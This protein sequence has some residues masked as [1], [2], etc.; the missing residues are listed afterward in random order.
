[1]VVHQPDFI[2]WARHV[3]NLSPIKMLKTNEVE[4]QES[5]ALFTLIPASTCLLVALLEQAISSS[6]FFM[7]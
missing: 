7:L 2:F 6:R 1:M 3:E 4:R 5:I